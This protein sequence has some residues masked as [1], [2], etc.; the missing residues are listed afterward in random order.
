MKKHLLISILALFITAIALGQNPFITNYTITDG[1]PSNKVFCVLQDK[2]GFMWF[3]TNAGIVRFDGTNYEHFTSKDGLSYNSIVRM[4]E[5]IEGRIWCLNIDGSVNYFYKNHFFN[6]RIS[7]FLGE[8]KTN[9]YYHDFFQDKD[10]TIYMYNGSGEVTIIKGN[11]YIDYIPS[12]LNGAVIF[13]ITK[14]SN[15]NLLFW[16]SNRIVEKKS[17][18]EIVAIHPL[19]FNIINVTSSLDGMTYV[20]DMEGNIHL[21]KDSRLVLRNYIS[22]NSKMINDILFK[23]DLIWISTF[24]NGLFCYKNDSLIFHHR[25]D[26]IQNL[27][28]DAQN[29]IWTSS[30][31]YGVFKINN[32]ILKYRTIE[33]EAFKN[34]GVK[35]IAPSNSDFLWLTNGESLFIFK[36]GEIF[37]KKLTV[38]GNILDKINL[39]TDNTLIVN[40]TNTPLHIFKNLRIDPTNNTIVYDTYIKSVTHAKKPIV[41]QSESRV[42]FYLN[43][44]LFYRELK[45]NY[46]QFRVNYNAWGRIRNIFYNYKQDIVVNGNSNRVISEDTINTDSIYSTFNGRWIASNVTIDSTSEVLQIED[47]DK[48]ELVLIASDKIYKLIHNLENLIDLK[49]KDM[50]YFEKTLFLFNQRTIYFIS[51]PTEVIQGTPAVLNRLDIEFNNINDIY[52]QDDILYVASDDGLTLIPVSE[53]VNAVTTPT[54]PYFSKV[55]L[56]D[57]EVNLIDDEVSYKN[58]NRLSIGFSSLNFSSSIT[59]YAYMLEGVNN[60]WITG[61]ENQVVY[62][63]LKPGK[64]TF[65]LKSRKNMEPYSEEIELPITVIPTFFQLLIT[66]I[67][68]VLL[69]LLLGF[70]AIRSYYRRQ[71]LVREKDNQLVTLENRAL[72][73]MMNPHFIFNSLG[74]I[75]KYLL[76]NKP[77]EAGTYLSQF[78]RLIRQTMNSIKSN[79][80]LLEDEVE[81]LRNYI[82][83]EKVRMENRFEFNILIDEKLEDDDYNIPSMIVQPFVENAIWH[84]IS[85]LQGKGKI[86]IRFNYVNEKSIEIVIED[87]GIGFE[88]SKAF[89]KTKNHLNMA[90]TL[91]QKRIQLIG[92]KYHVKT[93]IEFTDLYP[94]EL[95]PGAKITLLVPIVD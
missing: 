48:S 66:K 67:A 62:L 73:S 53:C 55:L 60:D 47:A 32:G 92:E 22:I 12:D 83:L 19:D 80:V 72:Q 39:L 95:N 64:Y 31:T 94:E 71:L 91:T 58:K 56:D 5:D 79:S 57:E 7:P 40:G 20:C 59:N 77:E 35:A 42:S 81:R 52:C 38:S 10:S 49:L 46:P 65:R 69:L 87:N 23:D 93:K 17:A 82:E 90:S 68:S 29:N 18:D 44:L 75:Q 88:K 45:D 78:A 61:T 21:F 9:F 13:N 43:D 33:A 26:K 30:T 15:N 11:R 8:I 86:A 27:I 2:N 16:D 24:D 85:Q 70:I 54:K 3:G 36:D 41:D 1:L 76:Q 84:G 6:E 37:D 50:I 34:M 51:N 74:S 14:S 63:N 28:L 89:S 4:K 25:M